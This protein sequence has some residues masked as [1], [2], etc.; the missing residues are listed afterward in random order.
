MKRNL[1]YMLVETADEMERTLSHIDNVT[2]EQSELITLI[3]NA[4]E[5]KRFENFTKELGA[6]VD[7][8]K[9]QRKTLEEQLTLLR[10]VIAE[11]DND[12]NIAHVVATLCVAFRIFG[13]NFPV[14]NEQVHT[15]DE[16]QIVTQE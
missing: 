7:N 4:D 10:E 11:C 5:S 3:T 6:N 16:E 15:K 14:E 8:T 1:T 9:Q 2:T 12:E 13:T